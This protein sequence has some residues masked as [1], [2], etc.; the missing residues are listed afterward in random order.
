MASGSCKSGVTWTWREKGHVL[1]VYFYLQ[2][3]LQH[4]EVSRQGVESELQLLVFATP[5]ATQDLSC[6][7]NLYHSS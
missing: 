5:T 4:M 2:L 3:H 1:F 7:C 6:I